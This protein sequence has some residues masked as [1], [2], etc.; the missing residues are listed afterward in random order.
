MRLIIIQKRWIIRVL[1]LLILVTVLPITLL[2]RNKCSETVSLPTTTK[3]IVIDPGHG[4]YDP[5]RMGTSGKDEKDIN[6]AISLYL[7]EYLEQSGSIVIMI[8]EE[9]TD[10]YVDDDSGRRMKTID[11]TNRKD[12]VTKNKPHALISIHVNSFPQSRYYGAQTFYSGDNEESKQLALIIQEELIRVLNSNNRRQ[13][14]EKNDV[15]IIKG[16]DM[17]AVLVECGFLSNPQ[18]EQRLNDPQ[19]QQKIAWS[20]Y[21][22][23]QRYFKTFFRE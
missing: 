7:R 9:D 17:P 11:L 19:Y 1:I 10:L 20:I 16:L 18:E 5:G 21:V 14:M 22:G 2:Y 15:Y 12:I 23:L 8:R 13:V 4:G 6:L 3:V